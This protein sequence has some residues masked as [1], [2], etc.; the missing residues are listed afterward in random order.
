M[1]IIG[2]PRE[3]FMDDPLQA[4]YECTGSLGTAPLLHHL[5]RYAFNLKNF[6]H[7]KVKKLKAPNL[8]IVH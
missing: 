6:L 5:I 8:T 2:L 1:T 7:L 4:G 3:V